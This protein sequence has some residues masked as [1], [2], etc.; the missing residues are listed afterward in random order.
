MALHEEEEE[1]SEL[2]LFPLFPFFPA[3][4]VWAFRP[5]KASTTRADTWSFILSE[6]K[7]LRLS[8]ESYEAC[9]MRR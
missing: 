3:C 7:V 2:L 1:G 6:L 5:N 9:V 8:E 4:A